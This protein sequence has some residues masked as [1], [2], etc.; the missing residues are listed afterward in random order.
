MKR[1]LEQ[2]EEERKKQDA[3][4][5]EQNHKPIEWNSILGEEIGEVSKAV[6]ESNFMKVHN[7]DDMDVYEAWLINYREELI[8]S[9]AVCVAMIESLERNEFKQIINWQKEQK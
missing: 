9:A 3:K 5:G 2:I 1:I 7:K 6:V 8:Q 4:W